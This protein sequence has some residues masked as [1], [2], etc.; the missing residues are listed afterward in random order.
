MCGNA[1]TILLL[2]SILIPHVFMNRHCM[3]MAQREEVRMNINKCISKEYA[4]KSFNEIANAPLEAFE[5]I[6]EEDAALLKKALHINTIRELANLKFFKWAAA[7]TTLADEDNTQK[8]HAEETILDDAIEMTFPSSDP[9]AVASNI[10]RVEAVPEMPDA[11]TD[12]QNSQSIE[13]AA[14][15]KRPLH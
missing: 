8:E 7:I 2:K 11:R 6:A 4:D 13:P 3:T 15:K 1:Q 14:E 12:H 9:I 10:T 5:G